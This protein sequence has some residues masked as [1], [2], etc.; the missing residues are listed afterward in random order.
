MKKTLISIAVFTAI[1]ATSCKEYGVSINSN[2]SPSEDTTYIAAAVE[3]AEP[4]NFLIEELSGVR[5]GNCPDAALKMEELIEQND[6]RLK[7]SV[8]HIGALSEPIKHKSPYSIQNFATDYGKKVVQLVFGEMGSMP[9]MS[10]D[11][12]NIGNE[13]NRYMVNGASNWASA[14]A[15]MKGK[16]NT[17]PVNIK[18]TSVFNEEKDQYDITTTLHY[19]QPV[20]GTNTLNI[21]ITE[22]KI[23]DAFID[24]DTLIT[25]NHVLRKTLTS[26]EGR[27]ILK[28]YPTKERGRVYVYRTTLKIEAS[29]PQQSKWDPDNMKVLAFVSAA[30]P[31]DKHVYQVQEIDLK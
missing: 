2:D 18:V 29:D 12:W 8:I 5:C 28:D 1:G 15:T 9:C 25:Y 30:E 27:V 6:H 26:S 21:F 7:V 3:Q 13:S 24:S 16:S 23:K 17:T 14:I 4:K 11:R 10:G 22:N 19:T 20:A 31:D